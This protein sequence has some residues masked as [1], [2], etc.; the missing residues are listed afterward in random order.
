MDETSLGKR[1][2]EARLARGWTQQQ[3]AA[4][5]GERFQVINVSRW[6]NGKHRPS[7]EHVTVLHRELGIPLD[8][9][10]KESHPPI[11]TPATP[12]GE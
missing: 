1:I 8:A 5:F 11:V 12:G 4:R 6:E 9:L 3:L 10:L 7:V 2:A